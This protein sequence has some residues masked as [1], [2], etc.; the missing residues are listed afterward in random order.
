[1][2]RNVIARPFDKDVFS[3]EKKHQTVFKSPSTTL[4]PGQ[5][6]GASLWLHRALLASLGDRSLC[7]NLSL[8]H[9]PGTDRCFLTGAWVKHWFMPLFSEPGCALGWTC[10]VILCA[11]MMLFHQMCFQQVSPPLCGFS[12]QSFLFLEQFLWVCLFF[13]FVFLFGPHQLHL[14]MTPNR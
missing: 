2:L 3:F 5:L 10:V 8:C 9:S 7:F 14:G 13:C 4:H 6:W 1:M 12:W 11:W